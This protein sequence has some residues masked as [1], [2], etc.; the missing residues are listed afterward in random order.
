MFSGEIYPKILNGLHQ[1]PM[2]NSWL[3]HTPQLWRV[4]LAPAGLLS[5]PSSVLLSGSGKISSGDTYIWVW[6]K[7]PINTIFSGMNIHLPA[8][9]GFTR[10]QGF[11]PYPYVYIYNIIEKPKIIAIKPT[12]WDIPSDIFHQY[13]MWMSEKW[14][15]AN[16]SSGWYP[17][18]GELLAGRCPNVQPWNRNKLQNQGLPLFSRLSKA[19]T[20]T[21]VCE[22]KVMEL[23][24]MW[25]GFQD[26]ATL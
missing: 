24:H 4:H 1:L 21:I 12:L 6:V 8:I 26:R 3:L 9:L 2:R 22:H 25:V 16:S 5:T 14:G 15:T 10:Y 20:S 23:E 19:I 18:T 13:D 11:D 7:I 17:A